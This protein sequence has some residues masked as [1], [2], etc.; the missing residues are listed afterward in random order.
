MTGIWGRCTLG[1]LH[2]ETSAFL[3]SFLIGGGQVKTAGT[4]NKAIR[5]GKTGSLF[6]N[7]AIVGTKVKNISTTIFEKAG[8]LVPDFTHS[9]IGFLGVKPVLAGAGVNKGMGAGGIPG[10]G[11]DLNALSFEELQGKVLIKKARLINGNLIL[12]RSIITLYCLFKRLLDFCK[13]VDISTFGGGIISEENCWIIVACLYFDNNRNDRGLG[14][15][16]RV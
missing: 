13:I 9:R 3:G 16:T 10:V 1:K 5:I 4:V 15:S 8:S 14:C 12:I 11:K 2:G 6:E 7:T